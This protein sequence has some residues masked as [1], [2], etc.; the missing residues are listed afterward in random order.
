MQATSQVAALFGK[1]PFKPLQQHMR[2]VNECV[3]EVPALFQAAIDGDQ[4]VLKTQQERIFEREGAA[5]Q[6]KHEI[7]GRFHKSIF[8][9]VDRADLLDLLGKQDAIANTAQDIAGVFVER[10]MEVPEGMAEPLMALVNRC[11]DAVNQAHLVIEE[12]DELVETGFRGVEARRVE[13]L[14]AELSR[15]EGET[16]ELGIRLSR[17]LFAQ[18]DSM[19]PVSVMFWYQLIQWTGDL[20]DHAEKVGNNLLLLIAR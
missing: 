6:I 4:A 11:V 9:P 2:I 17:H 19:K 1:S 10:R 20:A 12:L 5:D 3:A 15:I 7:R 8:M 16:D 18:E 13:E 14:V